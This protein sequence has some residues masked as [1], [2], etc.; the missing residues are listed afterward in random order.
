MG[1]ARGDANRL[2]MLSKPDA[3]REI[4]VFR[5]L[6]SGRDNVYAVR[7]EPSPFSPICEVP[8]LDP[9]SFPHIPNAIGNANCDILTVKRGGKDG[10]F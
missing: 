8:V 2:R 6:F 1:V 10:A 7:W 3:L 9:D 4:P 5:R